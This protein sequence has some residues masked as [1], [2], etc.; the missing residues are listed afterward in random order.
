MPAD[1]K[2]EKL[3]KQPEELM[4]LYKVINI[5]QAIESN[6]FELGIHEKGEEDNDVVFKVL[7]FLFL[8]LEDNSRINNLLKNL[9][10]AYVNRETDQYVS[11]FEQLS[12]EVSRIGSIRCFYTASKV[13]EIFN[14]F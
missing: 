13:L 4:N 14:D 7:S 10:L 8:D 9:T 2:T 5:R 12:K 3:D 1:L 6:K 11:T